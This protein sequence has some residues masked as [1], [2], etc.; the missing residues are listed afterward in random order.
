MVPQVPGAGVVGDDVDFAE[1]GTDRGEHR[2][3][4]GFVGDVA[5]I[6][7]GV[8]EFGARLSLV[9][10]LRASSATR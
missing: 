1:V 3:D 9:S 10:R 7:A 5:D 6:G 2:L 8:V 4:R